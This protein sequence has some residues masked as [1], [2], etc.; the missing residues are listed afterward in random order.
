MEGT[1]EVQAA[2]I[3]SSQAAEYVVANS[4]EKLQH[5][6]IQSGTDTH[7]QHPIPAL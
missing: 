7:A 3:R 1:R 4:P 5:R 6:G 2:V